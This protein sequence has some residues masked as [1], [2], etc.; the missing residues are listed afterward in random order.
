ML[1][2]DYIGANQTPQCEQC[3]EDAR[4]AITAALEAW[5]G[6]GMAREAAAYA[7]ALREEGIVATDHPD[8]MALMQKRSNLRFPIIIIRTE[9]EE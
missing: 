2:V 8:E 9:A 6:T 7:P 1:P 5:V 4:A 3:R